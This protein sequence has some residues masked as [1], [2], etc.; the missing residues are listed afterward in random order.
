L[1]DSSLFAALSPLTNAHV[2][3][4]GTYHFDRARAR[5]SSSA[6]ARPQEDE[7]RLLLDSIAG[8]D[9]VDLREKGGQHRRVPVH[10]RAAE[11][12]DA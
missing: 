2:I 6:P 11:A 12:L 7:P 1:T 9:L 3:P 8:D 4:S 10:S 5:D